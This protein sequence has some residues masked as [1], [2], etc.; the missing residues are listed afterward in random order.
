MWRLIAEIV[1]DPECG[2][3]LSDTRLKGRPSIDGL[4]QWQS[5]AVLI[6]W[7]RYGPAEESIAGDLLFGYNRGS[8]R[9]HVRS[10]V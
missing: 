3:G 4:L 7:K 8:A 10:I 9:R 1:G 2:G 6:C 5:E